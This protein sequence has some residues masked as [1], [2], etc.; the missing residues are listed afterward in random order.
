[1]VS[2]ATERPVNRGNAALRRR[3][4]SLSSGLP[5][6]L[7]S[8]ARWQPTEA[9]QLRASRGVDYLGRSSILSR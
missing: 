9:K 4:E 1:M 7:T 2:F 5:T 3:V 6:G 8:T